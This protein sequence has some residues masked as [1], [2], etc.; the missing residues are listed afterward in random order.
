MIDKEF[1]ERIKC[2]V[3]NIQILL[4]PMMGTD[5][6]INMAK[7]CTNRIMEMIEQQQEEG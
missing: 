6:R 3:G 2:E 1:I 7:T 4:T 5:K